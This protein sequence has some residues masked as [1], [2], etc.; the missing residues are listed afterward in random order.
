[1]SHDGWPAGVLA[2]A[3]AGALACGSAGRDQTDTA[4]VEIAYAEV[5]SGCMNCCD[6]EVRFSSGGHVTFIGRRACPVPG[7]QHFRIPASEFDE[8]VRAFHSAG[9]FSIPRLAGP[10][11]IDG[12]VVT[13]TYR[14]PQR[15]HETRH[16]AQPPA[17]LEQLASRLRR[18]SRADEI[19]RPSLERYTELVSRGWDV[20][21]LDDSHDNALIAT[22][23]EG[24]LASTRF[25]LS[26]GARLSDEAARLAAG[27]PEPEFLAITT[28]A[29]NAATPRRPLGPQLL[30]AARTS[31][32]NTKA[33]V[34]AGADVNWQ[35]PSSRRTALMSAISAGSLETA[36]L[37]LDHGAS[38]EARDN[39]GSTAMS[40]A[41]A[42]YNTGF[43]DMLAA[44]G[45]DPNA[46]DRAGRTPLMIA[47]DGCFEW[48]IAPLLAAGADPAIGDAKGRTAL[49]PTTSVV[50]DPKCART[51]RLVEEAARRRTL[52]VR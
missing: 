23:T 48:N 20:N 35:E 12:R 29:F 25:L 34:Q 32:A 49:Q 31:A 50:G 37:L 15:M 10:R 1:V 16:S 47:S 8:L 13:V 45:A 18:A 6:F 44:R 19:V 38:V 7:P 40:H 27:R 33:F 9:F 46:R 30:V 5:N 11:F 22:I 17:R 28:T 43:I 3:F 51:L 14:D 2:C 26:R 42:A 52:A 24:D 36:A 21:T 4:Q 41:A 39:Q